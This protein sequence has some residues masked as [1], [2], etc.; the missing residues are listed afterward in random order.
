MRDLLNS[1]HEAT[2]TFAPPREFNDASEFGPRPYRHV[3][4]I[5][6]QRD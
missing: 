3:S 5:Q 2:R 6:L 4:L 1:R